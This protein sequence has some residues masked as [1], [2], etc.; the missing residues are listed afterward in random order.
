V[1]QEQEVTVPVLAVDRAVAGDRGPD[2]PRD[3]GIDA[4]EHLP[5][6]HWD[7]VDYLI[8]TSDTWGAAV[9]RF[10]RYFAIISTGVRHVRGPRALAPA[11]HDLTLDAHAPRG[12]IVAPCAGAALTIEGQA[13]ISE[14]AER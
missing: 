14:G 6:G 13:H 3:T 9:K 11:A 7:V 12:R 8:G 1:R 4:A 10:D 2:R 5:W